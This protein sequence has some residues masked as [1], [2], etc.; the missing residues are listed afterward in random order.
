M[1]KRTWKIQISA[2]ELE[3]K[4][5]KLIPPPSFIIP[6]KKGK[7]ARYNRQKDNKIKVELS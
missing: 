4:I 2:R 6:P 3:A 1:K 5:R 7:G